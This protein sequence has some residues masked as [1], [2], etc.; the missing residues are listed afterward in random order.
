MTKDYAHLAIAGGIAV[1]NGFV[2]QLEM[3]GKLG[4]KGRQGIVQVD[5]DA[6]LFFFQLGEIGFQFAVAAGI[7]GS[8][9]PV[10]QVPGE[11]HRIKLVAHRRRIIA[12]KIPKSPSLKKRER[13]NR[14][15]KREKAKWF[16]WFSRKPGGWVLATRT[17]GKPGCD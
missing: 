10:F 16:Y 12:E 1:E 13:W 7:S 11:A 3:L 5:D 6:D 8:G 2:D 9:Q 14:R 17:P 15:E 4:G